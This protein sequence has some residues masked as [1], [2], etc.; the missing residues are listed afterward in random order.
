MTR[1]NKKKGKI[2]GSGPILPDTMQQQYE[3]DNKNVIMCQENELSLNGHCNINAEIGTSEKDKQEMAQ[4]EKETYTKTLDNEGK[5][6]LIN[7]EDNKTLHSS[8]CVKNREQEVSKANGENLGI[9]RHTGNDV[10]QEKAL[11]EDCVKL[12]E[13]STNLTIENN[14][15][16]QKHNAVVKT[17]KSACCICGSP[18]QRCSKCQSIVLCTQCLPRH[19]YAGRCLPWSVKNVSGLGKCLIAT[20]TIK[21]LEVVIEDSAV[22][23]VPLNKMSCLGCGRGVNCAYACPSCLLPMCGTGCPRA[24]H[25]QTECSLL[26]GC[27]TQKLTAEDKHHPIF[28]A[29]GCLRFL[30]MKS[31]EPEKYSQLANLDPQQKRIKADPLLS[32]LL[33]DIKE[34][35][36]NMNYKEEDIDHAYAIIKLYG[37]NLPDVPDG[38]VRSLFPVQSLLSHSCLPNLQ[39]IEKIGGRKIVLQ[40]T[41]KIE[42]GELLNV[43]YS[44]FLQGRI[45]LTKWLTEKRYINCKCPRCADATELGTFTSSALCHQ[46]ECKESGGLLLPV[47]PASRSDWI[48]SSCQE[49]TS[50]TKVQEIEE[51]YILKFKELPQGDL[52]E[53]YRF[54]NELGDRFHASHHLVMRMAQFLV[55]LQGK[56]L[57]SLSRERIETQS[58]LCDKLLAYVSRLD[59]GATQNRAKLLL[60]KNKA[61]LN[62]AKMDCEAGLINR[63]VFM[64]KIKEGVRVEVNA[65]KILYFKWDDK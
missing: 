9:L 46:E 61:D 18:G 56:R 15:D 42:K 40:S 41:T 19:F 60:E 13:V 62:L 49:L 63:K 8:P 34:L 25:H 10:D 27:V 32:K 47:D 44:P 52:N 39:Y 30:R 53:Y 17:S 4:N 20:R 2:S 37:Y 45:T 24:E 50:N 22:V 38:K 43:R 33:C 51:K 48:C 11:A 54:L 29:I 23:T 35:L 5:Q 6:N 16:I 64:A 58:V 65:K 12:A 21:P 31:E 14:E 3:P 7:D 28:T 26:A 55:L 59:P 57:E 36:K 1:K